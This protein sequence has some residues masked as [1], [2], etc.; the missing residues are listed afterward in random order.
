MLK[1]LHENLVAFGLSQK[2]SEVYITLLTHNEMTADEIAQS[3]S[4]NRSTVY[5]QLQ[6]LMN[7]GLAS[8]FKRGKKTLY[9]AE[10]PRHIERL[11]E[12]RQASIE[13]QKK[14]LSALIPDILRLVGVQS[15]R[16]SVRIFEGKEGLN[17][18]RNEIL[19]QDIKQVKIIT[20]IDQMR[21]VFTRDELMAFTTKRQNKKIESITLYADSES[22]E[23]VQPFPLQKL[24]QITKEQLPFGADVYI[25]GDHV[26]FASVQPTVIGVT[27]SNSGI[28]RTMEALFD[29]VWQHAQ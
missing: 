20:S 24:K 29:C 6:T 18:M 26:S 21:K 12:R 15:D 25:Y 22:T 1:K 17:T 5:V 9:V 14:E 27:I 10:S 4:L 2:E 19:S 28:A 8:T 13:T 7:F 3:S 11:L 23:L 16:P